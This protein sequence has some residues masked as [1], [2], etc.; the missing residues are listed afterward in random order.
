MN[1]P[2]Q[3]YRVVGMASDAFG[4]IRPARQFIQ[5][6]RFG[7]MAGFALLQHFDQP[8]EMIRHRSIDE[9]AIMRLQKLTDHGGNWPHD[10][11]IAFGGRLRHVGWI[12]FGAAGS[13]FI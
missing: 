8:G 3:V 12:G 4:A 1:K 13:T 5:G 11:G 6:G 2:P 9:V 10:V 7:S